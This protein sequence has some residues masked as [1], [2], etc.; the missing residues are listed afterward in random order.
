MV[1]SLVRRRLWATLVVVLM[2]V[3]GAPLTCECRAMTS[4]AREACH[5]IPTC[6]DPAT[7]PVFASLSCCDSDT[8]DTPTI[9]NPDPTTAGL[10]SARVAVA[11]AAFRALQLRPAAV[12][13]VEF[14]SPRQVVL[15]I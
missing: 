15:R 12:L 10:E 14:R 3:C 5:P 7:A 1:R 8:A 6:C 2:I 13:S 4:P 11:P 9:L